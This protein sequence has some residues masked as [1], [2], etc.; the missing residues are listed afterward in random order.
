MDTL[1]CGHCDTTATLESQTWA[2]GG[3]PDE[4]W[5]ICER[6]AYFMEWCAYCTMHHH[7]GDM[8][9]HN[10]CERCADLQHLR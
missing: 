4:E 6:C 8:F 9:D 5:P 2:I 7:P 1:T 3:Y 10:M